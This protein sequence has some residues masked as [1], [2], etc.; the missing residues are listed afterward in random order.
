MP[1]RPTRKL[2]TLLTFA[3][4]ISA[5]AAL[6]AADKNK[7][8]KQPANGPAQM[9]DDKRILH[10]L[11]RFAFG[12]RPGDVDKVRS[13]GL[14]KW[15]EEQLHPDKVDD[16]AIEARLTPFRT[17]K[18]STSDM[19]ENFPPPQILKQVENGRMS[20]PSDPGKRAIYESRIAAYE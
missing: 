14:D 10:A 18:M 6:L 1:M 15:F 3:L 9:D 13:I 7:S 2:F 20:M 16:N 8:K 19:V 12:P 5:A 11:N 17:L 4:L